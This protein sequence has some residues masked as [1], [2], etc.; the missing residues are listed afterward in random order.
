MILRGSFIH[1]DKMIP[2]TFL[3]E[4]LRDL[5]FDAGSLRQLK[6]LFSVAAVMFE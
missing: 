3:C 4:R 5:S 6:H 2:E 1:D